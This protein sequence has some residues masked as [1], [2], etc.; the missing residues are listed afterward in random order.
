MACHAPLIAEAFITETATTATIET[1]KT[2]WLIVDSAMT[3]SSFSESAIAEHT[4]AD[5]GW[6][7]H[8]QPSSTLQLLLQPSPSRRFPSSHKEELLWVRSWPSPQTSVQT[9]GDVG[10]PP[11]HVNEV[12]CVHELEHPSPL[13]RFPSS[14]TSGAIRRPSPQTALQVSEDELEPPEQL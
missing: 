9:L 10:D 11:V 5:P 4:L 14:Q 7:W 8:S 12:S 1:L 2:T 3:S 13:L 6:V